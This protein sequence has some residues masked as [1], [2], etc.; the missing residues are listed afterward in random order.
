MTVAVA[1]APV[2]TSRFQLRCASRAD[3]AELRALLRRS[4]IPG[5]ISVTFE[6]E[7]DFFDACVIHGDTQVGIGCDTGTGR[8]VGMGTRS[9]AAAFVNGARR[10]VGYLAD[11]R[12]EPPH[13]NGTLVVRGYRLLR[14]MHAD[15][16]VDMYTTVIFASNRLALGTIASGRAG[17]PRYHDIGVVHC[18]GINVRGRKRPIAVD[19]AMR[20]GTTAMLD[21]IVD[22]LN[23]NNARRQFAPVHSAADFRPGGRWKDFAL[24]DFHVAVREKRVV[25]VAGVWDQRRFKQTRIVGYAPHLGIALPFVN[26]LRRLTGG[27]RYARA[28]EYL[29]YACLSFVAVDA[30]DERVLRALVRAAYNDQVG[31]D[32]V[33]LMMAVHERDPWLRVVQDYSI[34]PFQARLFCVS[35]EDG[36][37][38]VAA[39]DS[40]VPHV[41]AALL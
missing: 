20:R 27:P 6:R 1:A 30:D 10:D 24:S 15:G 25:G 33:Y 17:L 16:R 31:R 9:I 4:V 41:E 26:S 3:E 28:G 21:E 11:L 22:C 12:L 32:R 34:T 19:C 29:R 13:R 14:Q 18:P 7:P 36:A 39:L 23:R 2:S 38:A 8:I 37:A 35:F 40:R 5:D